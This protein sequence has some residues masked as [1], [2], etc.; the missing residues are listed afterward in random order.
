MFNQETEQAVQ[1]VVEVTA[2]AV[3]AEEVITGVNTYG[4]SVDDYLKAMA[5]REVEDKEI[6]KLVLDA[7]RAAT[8]L[9]NKLVEYA[10]KFSRFPDAIAQNYI[11]TQSLKGVGEKVEKTAKE[12]MRAAFDF[13]GIN[14]VMLTN[15]IVEM[16]KTPDGVTFDTSKFKKLNPYD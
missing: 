6:H 16:V 15:H 9:E 5:E 10:T 11:Y 14:S 2:P 12:K 7:N 13:L 1:E 4:L 8:E 3:V